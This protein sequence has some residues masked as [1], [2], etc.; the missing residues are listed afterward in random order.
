MESSKISN[1]EQKK[2]NKLNIKYDLVSKSDFFNP[3]DTVNDK[4]LSS[5]K[6]IQFDDYKSLKS[7]S[8]LKK[9]FSQYKF[10]F[11]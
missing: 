6:T 10:V 2:E 1:Y 7:L 4:K 3:I 5:K 8:E 9:F 11:F